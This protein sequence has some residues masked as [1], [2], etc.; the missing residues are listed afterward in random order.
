M[1]LACLSKR[2]SSSESKLE[3]SDHRVRGWCMEEREIEEQR[4]RM[5]PVE[6]DQPFESRVHCHHRA[7]HVD[8]SHQDTLKMYVTE[9]Q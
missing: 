5:F 9:L 4:L 3:S 6:C 8:R 2:K 1:A 7:I